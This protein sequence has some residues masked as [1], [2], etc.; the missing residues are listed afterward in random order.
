ML[1]NKNFTE[2]FIIYNTIEH[3]YFENAYDWPVKDLPNIAPQ[4]TIPYLLYCPE[5]NAY[6]EKNLKFKAETVSFFLKD[7]KLP[8]MSLGFFYNVIVDC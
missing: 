3:D 6:I 5:D 2:L 8:Y 7:P 4:T 1:C